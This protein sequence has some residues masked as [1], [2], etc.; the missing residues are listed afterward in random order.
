MSNDLMETA[1]LGVWAQALLL[2]ARECEVDGSEQ[3]VQGDI[4]I[5]SASSTRPWTSIPR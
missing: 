3:A 4:L 5:I 1:T 2:V